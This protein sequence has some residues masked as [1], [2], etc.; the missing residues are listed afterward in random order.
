MKEINKID[1]TQL[2]T[3]IIESLERNADAIDYIENEKNHLI[4]L[5]EYV[6]SS[7]ALSR[8]IE[9]LEYIQFSLKFLDDCYIKALSRIGG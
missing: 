2:R 5:L 1:N 6:E 7:H 3:S 8:S 4:D 9:V